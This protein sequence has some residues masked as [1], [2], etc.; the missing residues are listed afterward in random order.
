MQKK[1]PIPSK[2]PQHY[3]EDKSDLEVLAVIFERHGPNISKGKLQK[4]DSGAHNEVRMRK[5][6]HVFQGSDGIRKVKWN[7]F[8]NND[9]IWLISNIYQEA[10]LGE[11]LAS[12]NE[13]QIDAYHELKERNLGKTYNEKRTKAL[14]SSSNSY[15]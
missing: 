8:E 11:L 1:G 12:G 9:L 4:D 10:S 7:D 3:W 13:E 15:Q 5:L 14:A 6:V 2:R